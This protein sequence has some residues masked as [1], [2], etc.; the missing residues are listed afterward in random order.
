MG[1]IEF[2]HPGFFWLFALLPFLAVWLW[3]SRNRQNAALQMSRGA[4]F[5]I[6]AIWQWMPRLLWALRL[7]ALSLFIIGLA[8][9]RSVDVSSKT[10]SN[11]GID[12]VLSVDVS[13]SMLARDLKPNRLEALKKVAKDFVKNR[14][15]D[16]IG[17]VVYTADAYTK[18]PLTSDKAILE[19]QIQTIQYDRVLKD[20]TGIGMGLATAINRIK[21]SVAKSKIII[22]M[23]DGVNN[24]G[25]IEPE[26]A[27][28]IA[29]EYGIKVYTIG[30][31][32]KGMAE[33]PY[34]ISP[35]GSFMYRQM[36]VEIDETLLKTVAEKTG[37]KYSRATSNTSLQTIYDEI[38]QL[39]TTEIEELRFYDY[40]E[41]FRWF[42]LAG[43]ILLLLELLLRQTLFKNI[44]Q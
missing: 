19:H 17:L 43:L 38:N 30:I 25:F 40:Q 37:G 1:Q 20:G 13:A 12:I 36:P 14:P 11:K 4:D 33:A 23:T 24:S 35:N 6:S 28:S 44:V 21:E 9:P 16:R 5:K 15:N 10:K 2:M 32:T 34:A 22:L 18:T 26:L 39:E 31:G 27:T 8:R 7:L 29:Q 41:H 3:L 42:V